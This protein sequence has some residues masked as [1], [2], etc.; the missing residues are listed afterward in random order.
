[1]YD[2]Q[3]CHKLIKSEDK[4]PDFVSKVFVLACLGSGYSTQQKIN[5]KNPV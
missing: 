3:L 5:K 4:R 2:R 1:M